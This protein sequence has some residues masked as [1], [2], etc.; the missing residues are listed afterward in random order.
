LEDA[1]GEISPELLLHFASTPFLTG[2]GQ[3]VTQWSLMESLLDQAI[4]RAFRLSSDEGRA[5][6]THMAVPAR[7]DLLRSIFRQQ[8]GR[9]LEHLNVVL[10]EVGRVA[11]MRNRVV[12]GVILDMTPGM[13]LRGKLGMLLS[14][15]ARGE[16]K[17]R[18]EIVTPDWLGDVALQI[19]KVTLMLMRLHSKEW[20]QSAAALSAQEETP[21][22]DRRG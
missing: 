7:C 14:Y 8:S 20:P 22:A 9:D 3:I 5:I 17:D 2:V 1:A 16:L 19:T 18:S 13:E 6:T 11:G 10:A 21:P 15:T 12:H 4:W